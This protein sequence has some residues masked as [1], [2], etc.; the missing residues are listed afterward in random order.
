MTNRTKHELTLSIND[1]LLAY[2]TENNISSIA[3]YPP[4]IVLSKQIVDSIRRVEYFERARRRVN[5]DTIIDPN[6][7][8]FDP[9]LASIKFTMESRED[10]AAWLLFLVVHFGKNYRSKW[11]LLKEVYG[12]L[13]LGTLTFDYYINNKKWFSTWLKDHHLELIG[14]FGNH[15]K[16]ETKK[17]GNPRS[18]DNVFSSFLNWY[19]PSNGY[20]NVFDYALQ[21]TDD[22]RD[23]FDFLYSKM[24]SIVSF[25]RL[26]RFD[27]L[28]MVAKTKL[29]NIIPSRA[30]ISGNNGPRSGAN[31]LFFNNSSHPAS[32]EEL[33]ALVSELASYL[34]LGAFEMQILEDAL[35]NWQKDP[36]NYHLFKG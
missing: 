34:E 13:G 3:D 32:S 27:Y 16:F 4:R 28:T 7:P 33:E 36:L 11:Q 9:V 22:S 12:L 24:N 23:A 21:E 14:M 8:G 35:C 25:G 10:E 20:N 15:R 18:I 6:V 30:Y 1:K 29:Y 19:C 17:Y 5:C 31:L 2:S 26:A